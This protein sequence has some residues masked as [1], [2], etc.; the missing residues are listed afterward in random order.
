MATTTTHSVITPLLDASERFFTTLANWFEGR[1]RIQSRRDQIEALER[2]T[3][4]ELSR[5]GLRRDQIAVHVFRD[6]FYT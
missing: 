3:D 5:L 1:M 6:K 2:K 4:E